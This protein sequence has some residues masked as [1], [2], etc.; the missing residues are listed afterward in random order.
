MTAYLVSVVKQP[1]KPGSSLVHRDLVLTLHP[2]PRFRIRRDAD[3]A[4]FEGGPRSR[5]RLRVD[6][7][8][9]R[10]PRH[11]LTGGLARLALLRCL[12]FCQDRGLLRPH[13][14]CPHPHHAR[15]LLVNWLT[16][17]NDDL[18]R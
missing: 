15:V 1:G 7:E 14:Q 18:T 17:L 9:Q 5:L 8:E 10:R 6:L 4:T 11:G 12:V 2:G 13:S 16:W 3:V